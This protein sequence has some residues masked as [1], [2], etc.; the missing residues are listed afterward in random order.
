M[1]PVTI[2]PATGLPPDLDYYALRKHGL[3]MLQSLSSEVWTDYNIHDPGVTI[4]EHLCFAMNELAYK[5]NLSIEDIIAP[6][7]DIRNKNSIFFSADDILTSQPVTI[8]DY[9]KVI[10]D[11]FPTTVNNCWIESHQPYGI[12]TGFYKVAVQMTDKWYDEG[13][14]YEETIQK[15][16]LLL[17]LK[18][19]IAEFFVHV[20]ILKPQKVQI[21]AAFEIENDANENKVLADIYYAAAKAILPA[22]TAQA[23]YQLQQAG[24][25][26]EE[27]FEGPLLQNGF[28]RDEQ[29]LPKKTKLNKGDVLKQ[30]MS[31]PGIL[32]QKEFSMRVN[33][34]PFFNEIPV[35]IE[36]VLIFDTTWENDKIPTIRLFKGGVPVK[37]NAISFEKYSREL[38]MKETQLHRTSNEID[39][40]FNIETKQVLDLSYYHSIQHDFPLNYGLGKKRIGPPNDSYKNAVV[41]QLKGYLLI[42]EQIIA[43][44]QSQLASVHKLLSSDVASQQ[45]SYFYQDISS[46]PRLE[47]VIDPKLYSKKQQSVY[48][49][50]D[51]YLP[52]Q[53]AILDHLLARFGETFPD[54][55]YRK[56]GFYFN[57]ELVQQKL[58]QQKTTFL[59]EITLLTAYRMAA[60]SY[61]NANERG[62]ISPL[63]KKLGLQLGILSNKNNIAG[64]HE[65]AGITAI[66]EG[67]DEITGDYWYDWK[68]ERD[69]F[70]LKKH[71][72][73]FN[74][75]D[76][77]SDAQL[78]K[79]DFVL[80]RELLQSV[81]FLRNGLYF[82]NYYCKIVYDPAT[83]YELYYRPPYSKRM[84]L[85]AR[86]HDFT[87]LL[88][89]LKKLVTFLRNV[90]LLSETFSIMEHVLLLPRDGELKF[91]T[92]HYDNVPLW[93]FA[94]A[95]SI[96][97]PGWTK[98]FDNAEFRKMAEDVIAQ[99]LPAH[100]RVT[101]MW[102][103]YKDYMSYEKLYNNRIKAAASGN[104]EEHRTAAK[105]MAQFLYTLT[106]K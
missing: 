103:N 43:N 46:I 57:N 106:E 99:N 85:V 33:D 76:F 21:S 18:R 30:L 47:A 16:R 59:K 51:K 13:H 52:R 84:C 34:T 65:Q 96:V 14:D 101:I 104:E 35:Q 63:Q 19:N 80:H 70:N 93:F 40:T 5:T 50:L 73:I 94:S 37:F 49:G 48:H 4:L 64:I 8:N 31:V 41:K 68:K 36:Q 97:F 58:V 15:I 87:V 89:E 67:K 22:I 92:T 66:M 62:S 12:P 24:L 29:L 7:L 75:F 71:D 27:I 45:Q 54:P 23:L 53:L 25:P 11:A 56:L 26:Y 83:I 28:I 91:A 10:L 81:H 3:K 32:Q 6:S 55:I 74:V 69:L 88:Y 42:P 95:V 61:T 105:E 78:K 90:N 98:R 20:T 38:T 9:R 1:E 77:T 60:P 102:L 72:S 39:K 100:L 82:D 79:P 2:S 17:N 44:Y 86:F